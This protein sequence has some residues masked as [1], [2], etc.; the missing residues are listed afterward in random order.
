MSSCLRG[1]AGV[2][3]QT[4]LFR[5]RTIATWASPFCGRSSVRASASRD[6]RVGT[7]AALTVIM[8]TKPSKESVEPVEGEG[9]HSA[10]RR[11]NEGAT[12][13]AKDADVEGLARKAADALDGPEGDDLRKAEA[14]AKRG[15]HPK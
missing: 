3:V 10:S 4:S 13:H 7:C 9:S 1:D 15:P 6:P 12:K 14:E 5:F 8:K 2:S 11:Y